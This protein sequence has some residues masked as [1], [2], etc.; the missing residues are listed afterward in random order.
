MSTRSTRAALVA[1][2]VVFV[3]NGFLFAS[4]AARIPAA[5]QLLH[6]SSGQ[7]GGLLLFGAVGSLIS[8][9]LS[10]A[11]VNRLGSASSVRVGAVIAAV[12]AAALGG[13]LTAASVPLT[14]V[15]LFVLGAGIALWDVAM[16]IQGTEVERALRATVLPKLH[17]GFS[18]GAFI[19]ALVGAGMAGAGVALPAHLWGIVVLAIVAMAVI[20][21][22]FLPDTV[23]EP[24]QGPAPGRLDA[25]KEPRTLV[26]GLIVLGAALT[27]GAAN[28]WI[29]KAAVDGLG[30]DQATGALTFAA[31]VLSMTVFRYAGS[32]LVDRFGRVV[33]L[34]ASFATGLIGVVLFVLGPG[35]V[36]ALIGAVL[37][38][39]GAAMGFPLGISA[40]ADEP[41]RAAARV[42]VV[43]T[44]GYSAFLAGPPLLGFLG[45]HVGIR[46]ALLAVGAVALASTFAVR[47]ARPDPVPQPTVESG[48]RIR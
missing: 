29:A 20:P 6:L 9:P 45:D 12:G 48:D 27:E 34:Y 10:G 23:H 39:A 46:T 44:I 8:L 47:A 13:A 33:V 17:A 28:D 41:R 16:N 25:W 4:W 26:L 35:I 30:V 14:G 11:I 7:I 19:G 42:S 37:W 32:A 43:T 38:G 40:A 18:G 22:W 15:A 36:P 2:F 21:R 5:A 24:H 1:T 3:F 31:F